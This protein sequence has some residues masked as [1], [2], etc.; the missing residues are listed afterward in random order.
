MQSLIKK[1]QR[2]TLH[3]NNNIN[4]V[5][6]FL[7]LHRVLSTR[8]KTVSDMQAVVPCKRCTKLSYMPRTALFMLLKVACQVHVWGLFSIMWGWRLLEKQKNCLENLS[9]YAWHFDA[10]NQNT[11]CIGSR[12]EIEGNDK[13][14]DFAEGLVAHMSAHA[15]RKWQCRKLLC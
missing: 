11:F 10:L 12:E 5:T 2:L 1:V 7:P 4:R 6:C 13:I 9:H 3:G 14:D 8:M 15:F